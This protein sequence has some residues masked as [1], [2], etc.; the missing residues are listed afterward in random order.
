MK[1]PSAGEVIEGAEGLRKVRHSGARTL[2]NWEQGR[3]G[4]TERPDGDA[5]TLGGALPDTVERL[6]EV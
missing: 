3:A 6:A 4:Q 5:D 2:E 1:N